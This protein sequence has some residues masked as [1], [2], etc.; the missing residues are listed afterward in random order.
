MSPSK[1]PVLLDHISPGSQVWCH[2]L[3]RSECE[4]GKPTRQRQESY[5][6][7]LLKR[8][9]GWKSQCIMCLLINSSILG[10]DSFS[11]AYLTGKKQKV[12]LPPPPACGTW[13]LSWWLKWETRAITSPSTTWFQISQSQPLPPRRWDSSFRLPRLKHHWGGEIIGT[14]SSSCGLEFGRKRTGTD[15]QMDR[16][17][18]RH[19]NTHTLY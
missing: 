13:E 3:A 7:K 2:T 6:V 4:E 18:D 16:E 15:R 5:F 11:E 19:T 17:T 10:Y 14:C 12:W 9:I 1:G 8:V